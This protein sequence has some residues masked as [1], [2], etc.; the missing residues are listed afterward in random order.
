M[1]S[2]A[3]PSHDVAFCAAIL[4]AIAT[5]TSS[6]A[7]PAFTPDPKA[8][9]SSYVT[10]ETE[11]DVYMMIAAWSSVPV[12]D[13]Q[14]L[15]RL[16]PAYSRERD[17]FKRQEIGQRDLATIKAKIAQY[18]TQHYFAIKMGAVG[19]T[20]RPS[21]FL[22]IEPILAPFDLTKGT[23]AAGG[24]PCWT[25]IQL[26]VSG[27]QYA[28]NLGT[29]LAF[30][31]AGVACDIKVTDVESAKRIEAVRSRFQTHLEGTIYFAVTD[32]A[33]PHAFV[34]VI[35]TH[36]H[37]VVIDHGKLSRDHTVLS[38]FDL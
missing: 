16:S 34:P 21:D 1:R 12:T 14:L 25:N 27:S 11:A 6:H 23:F 22:P 26:A 38:E 18:Q 33:P 9:L 15:E 30:D 5:Q 17:Q 4:L 20:G 31:K 2:F 32:K 29:G 7:G 24:T 37:A 19:L 36:V 10:L 28:S 35:T 8:P 13:E 3:R